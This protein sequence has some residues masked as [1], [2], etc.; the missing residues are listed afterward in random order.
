MKKTAEYYFGTTLV[1]W[2]LLNIFL[3][4]EFL[5][6]LVMFWLG[7]YNLSDYYRNYDEYHIHPTQNHAS[8]DKK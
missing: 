8:S 3:Y 4:E 5:L 1:A 7:V 6:G 2:G